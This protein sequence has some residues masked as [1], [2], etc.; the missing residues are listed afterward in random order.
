MILTGALMWLVAH[1]PFAL[2][3]VIPFGG[4]I[5]TL[6]IA[7]GL[8]IALLGMLEFAK[9]KTTLNPIDLTA[10][11]RLATGGVYRLSRNPMYLGLTVM[12]LG[13][14]IHLASPL[15]VLLIAAFIWYLTRF[16]IRHEEAAMRQ[17]FGEEY[18]EFCKKVRRWL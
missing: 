12:L 8:G 6:V 7:T 17:L 5:R 14:A 18:A 13:W 2:R 4:I 11:T 10:S 16:Q 3:V 9:L 1:S 15:N